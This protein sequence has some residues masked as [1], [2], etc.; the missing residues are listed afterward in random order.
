MSTVAVVIPCY[1]AGRTLDDA[2]ES[3]LRQTRPVTELVVVDDGS[4]DLYTRER[5]ALL[6]RRGIVVARGARGGPAAARNRGAARTSAPY[7]LF[8]DADDILEPTYLEQTTV[9]LDRE[10]GIHFVSTSIRAF[11]EAN[12]VWM[13]PPPELV[14][15]LTRGT[16]PVTA[17]MRRRV[18]ESVGGFDEALGT[19]E[20][21]DFWIR[22][23]AAGFRGHVIDEPL[24][25]YRVR[26]DSLHHA[27]VGRDGHRRAQEMLY[28]KH[29][30]LIQDLGPQ[31]L[32]AKEAFVVE[33]QRDRA[34]LE[35]WR[36][37]LEAER[38]RVDEEIGRARQALLRRGAPVLDLADLDRSTP[39]SPVWGL[40]RGRP[41]D[42]YYIERFLEACRTDIRGRVLEVKDGSYTDAFGS[43][44]V[45]DRDVLDV[46]AENPQA[47][48]IADLADASGIASDTFDCFIL[49][50]TLH[51]IHDVRAAVSHAHRILRPGGVLLATLPAVSRINDENGGL[52]GG[53]FWRFTEA[54][55][56]R[57]FGEVFGPENVE[58]AAAGNMKTAIG[59]L[60]GFAAEDFLAAELDHLDR[61]RPLLFCVRAVKRERLPATGRGGRR[62]AAAILMYHRIAEPD[63]DPHGLSVA[64]A[65]FLAQMRQI[66]RTHRVLPLE[67]LAVA[68]GSGEVPDGAVA[69]TFDDGTVDVLHVA[70]PILV[71]LGV[72]ATFFVTTD[73]L[74]DAHEPWWQVLARI[75]LGQDVLPTFVDVTAPDGTQRRLRCG[76]NAERAAAH[77]AIHRRL[78]R[79]TRQERDETMRALGQWSGVDLAPRP[80]H[81]LLLGDEVRR[82]A[83]LPGLAVGSH[84]VHHLFLPAQP[85]AE[86]EREMRESKRDLERVVGRTV[87][88]LSY[89]YG[90]W[91]PGTVGLARE[92]GYSA[93]VTAEAG[94]VVPGVDVYR[95]PRLE[96]KAGGLAELGAL[97]QRARSAM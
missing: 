57:L 13:P 69:I 15:A 32:L 34:R 37:D 29:R 49:T 20:D 52:D 80:G 23:F 89:P 16:I 96:I 59:F 11:G 2:V 86:S 93:A 70:A 33:Q 63:S 3:V 47:T 41:V 50:Q 71:G 78:V 53:D 48:V 85:I 18:W 88:L 35:Q 36:A 60:Y 87:T 64:P 55:V 7:L 61:A 21:L 72:P 17:L 51:I 67:E 73:R 74:D 94:V 44:S 83:A 82:L 46:V 91:D 68:T 56:G 22:V 5:L 58:V 38:R 27:A 12:Y 42:R 39:V 1:N 40:D 45:T 90:A 24:L 65:D 8:V 79:A 66:A 6:A 31:L 84:S 30:R 77:A 43:G 97:L 76:T 75:F 14:P 92:A 19:S 9:W 81:R 26:A 4:T 28:R 10:T 95:L 62:P 25:R 54:G